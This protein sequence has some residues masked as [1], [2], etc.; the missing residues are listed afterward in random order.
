[1]RFNISAEELPERDRFDAWNAAIFSTLAIRVEPLPDM[2][3]P[4]HARFSARASGPLMN[5]N[6]D[7][8]GFYATHQNSELAHRMWD[9]YWIYRELGQGAWFNTDGQE[10]VSGPDDL[11]IGDTDVPFLSRPSGR[12]AHQLWVVPKSM[13]DPHLPALGRPL[14]TRLSGRGGIE[15]LATSYLDTLA[16]EWEDISEAEMGP[17]TETLC[18]LIGVACGTAAGAHPDAIRAGRL[19]GARRYIGSHLDDPA[20]SPANAAASL[21]ISVRALHLLFESTDTS[22]ARTVLRRRLEECRS[23]L[24]ANPVRPVTDIAFAWGFNNLSTFYRAFQAAFGL[25]PGDLRAA[26]NDKQHF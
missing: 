8:D 11:V 12:Y 3:Q 21:G 6:F 15:A 14:L 22:F 18:R 20:L 25:T 9:C 5:C 7:A 16:R 4:F 10:W 19:T 2:D 24:L 13:I 26:S 17:V 23:A 1:M